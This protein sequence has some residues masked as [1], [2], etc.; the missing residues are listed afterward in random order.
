ML[1]KN[2]SISDD[3]KIKIVEQ[4]LSS[5]TFQKAPKS[6]ALLRYLVK[7]TIEGIYLKEDVID[8]EFFGS[9]SSFDKSNPRVRVNIYNLRKK[10]EVYYETDGKNDNWR[11]QIDK[12]QYGVRFEKNLSENDKK[13]SQLLL[14]IFPFIIILILLVTLIVTNLPAHQPK[15][16]K[17]Y[18]SNKKPTT[19][20]IG[21]V[22]GIMWETITGE[23][24]WTRDFAINNS[25]DFY[26]YLD[27]HP[28]LKGTIQPA[29]FFYSTSMGV[30]SAR[31]IMR[32]FSEHK[33]DFDIRFSS[34]TQI[35]DILN[36]NAIYVGPIFNKNK[37]IELF[38]AGNPY[39]KIREH[40]LILSGSELHKDT[41][42]ATW[43]K[44]IGNDM[45]IAIVSRFKGPQ[46][47]EQFVFFSNHDIGVKATIDYFTNVDS[48]RNFESKYLKETTNF[49]AVYRVIGKDRTQLSIHNVVVIPF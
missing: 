3:E 36:G 41:E 47:S 17:D 2:I 22:Y 38:N 42:Y 15:I 40:K 48:L 20:V 44:G 12:G 31:D 10:L 28:D 6:I 16:W 18:F 34:N 26:A 4:I 7:A 14:K 5:S 11:I 9:K 19:L 29:I 43:G 46:D 33:K 24:G 49:T 39:F 8:Y 1:E 13:S 37:F 30:K 27:K 35:S 23:K 45:D 25:E 21:D 32:L